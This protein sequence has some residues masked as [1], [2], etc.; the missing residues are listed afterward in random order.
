MTPGIPETRVIQDRQAILQLLPGPQVL[1]DFQV[2]DLQ[3]ERVI[4]D[5]KVDRLD[6]PASREIRGILDRLELTL[7]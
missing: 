1:R 3:A 5:R 4:L 6:L 2:Q 7:R